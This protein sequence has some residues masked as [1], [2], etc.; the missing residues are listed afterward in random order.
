MHAY[1]TD[2]YEIY[3]S[4]GNELQMTEV[5]AMCEERVIYEEQE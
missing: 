1:D 5:P 4:V 3:L 2:G